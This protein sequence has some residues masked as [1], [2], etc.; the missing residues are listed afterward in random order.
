MAYAGKL[1]DDKKCALEKIISV[2]K[3]IFHSV[4]LCGIPYLVM[5]DGV[6]EGFPIFVS[7]Q[8]HWGSKE[9]EILK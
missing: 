4:Q 3:E 5:G 9:F 2:P 7:S 8:P 1:Y 6:S